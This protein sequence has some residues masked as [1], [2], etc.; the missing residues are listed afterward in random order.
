MNALH[1]RIFG[2]VQTVG[3]RN[4]I[5]ENA[6]L[7]NLTGWTR[8]ASD[9][10]VEV[11]LQ[12]EIEVLNELLA[13]LWEGPNIAQVEDVLTQDARFDESITSFKIY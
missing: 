10:S 13:L 4:W 11:F 12:G 2:Q 3:F 8:N 7:K 6:D 9:G 5:K 1:V